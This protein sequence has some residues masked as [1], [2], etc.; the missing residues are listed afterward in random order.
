MTWKILLHSYRM[1][2]NNLSVA[3]RIALMPWI[4]MIILVFV[5]NLIRF[6]HLIPL[7]EDMD[8]ILQLGSWS[9]F[10][11]LL[12]IAA[13]VSVY[14]WVIVGWHRFVLLGEVPNGWL[15]NWH[16]RQNLDYFLKGI[17]I[18]LT[19]LIPLMVFGS[20]I[21]FIGTTALQ[22]VL[23]TALFG[24][25]FWFLF[26]RLSLVL[27]AAA[28][29]VPMKIGESWAVTKNASMTI[30]G[31]AAILMGLN[32]VMGLFEKILAGHGFMMLVALFLNAVIGLLSVSILTT[33]Y[34]VLIEEREL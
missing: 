16:G 10:W 31:L 28:L 14:T 2:A 12:F 11:I 29:G 21:A 34:G 6:G 17:L 4:F 18:G 27:P 5:S 13:Y 22:S 1:I 33:L 23:F 24:V 30:L 9:A 8:N 32:I 3:F 19:L 7:P 26:M 25:L 15:P 20:V